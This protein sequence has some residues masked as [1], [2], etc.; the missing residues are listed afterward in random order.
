MPYQRILFDM[1]GTLI[2]S[3]PGI[4]AA[5][6]YALSSAGFDSVE[7]GVIRKAIGLPLLPMVRQLAPTADDETADQLAV[8]YR[9]YF[10]ET[11][12]LEATVYGGVMELL[13]H[14]LAKGFQLHVV[15]SK[16]APFVEKV[17]RAFGFEACFAS[18]HAPSLGF[19]PKR[20]AELIGELLKG[21]D[22][23]PATCL[24]IGDRAE[25]ILSAR[26]NAIDALGVTYGFGTKEELED[27]GTIAVVDQASHI[28]TFLT[29]TRADNDA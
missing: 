11:G 26:E 23:Q 5:M 6:R 25:D 9:E 20:K 2:D 1:D 19:A 3:S 15:T 4:V 17:C 21:Y 29:D 16:P 24:M 18:V 7:E 28:E 13:D 8:L 10:A 27:A 14:L 22:L 12:V